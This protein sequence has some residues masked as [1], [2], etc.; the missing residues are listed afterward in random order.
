M[1]SIDTKYSGLSGV[2]CYAITMTKQ[3][4]KE[5]TGARPLIIGLLILILAPPAIVIFFI[6]F[7]KYVVGWP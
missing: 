5:E 2:F 3:K 7:V 4:Q 1:Q 6:L